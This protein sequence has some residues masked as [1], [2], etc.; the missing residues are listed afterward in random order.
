MKFSQILLL[1]ACAAKAFGSVLQPDRVIRQ[2]VKGTAT[3]NLAT[4][5]G[6]PEHIAAGFLY[7][8]PI[9]QDQIPDHFYTDMGFNY[10]RSGG[11]SQDEP[12]RGWAF[13]TTE[14][15]VSFSFLSLSQINFYPLIA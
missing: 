15:T 12:A 6:T 11:G 9:A 13:G 8:I 7:G 2:D 1:G 5:I 3:I 14:F 10:G 4:P